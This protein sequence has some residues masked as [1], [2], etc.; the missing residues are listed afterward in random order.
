MSPEWSYEAIAAYAALSEN[1]QQLVTGDGGY[2]DPWRATCAL[3]V[4]CLNA[5]LGWDEFAELAILAPI[6]S[7]SDGRRR[8]ENRK[9]SRL[10]RA[11]TWATANYREPVRGR[12]GVLN[13]LAKLS[14]RIDRAG[15]PGRSGTSDHAVAMALVGLAHENCRVEVAA[16]QRE[17]SLRAGVGKGTVN[18][19]I[20][21]LLK[22]GLLEPVVDQDQG[23][24]D[25]RRYRLNLGWRVGWYGDEREETGHSDTSPREKDP[26]D[27]LVPS[28]SHPAFYLGAIGPT[29]GRLY[30][31]VLPER[32][33]TARQAGARLGMSAKAA[34]GNLERLV[35]HGLASKGRQGRSAVY[36]Y[37][38]VPA[39]RLDE[40]AAEYGTADW[41]ER[42]SERYDRER[43]GY[44]VRK[45]QERTSFR[46]D[47]TRSYGVRRVLFGDA[48][49]AT[50]VGYTYVVD[51]EDPRQIIA[52]PVVHE[53]D[54]RRIRERL[55]A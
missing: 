46:F 50:P 9:E 55:Y 34:R 36:E 28:A 22:I 35:R 54:Q 13:A 31:E 49:P 1:G 18:R 51:P 3:A 43:Q 8:R 44:A 39:D 30:F 24:L 32:S 12:E 19:S 37:T 53:R 23:E 20:P 15:W 7:G 11:W 6:D 40:L 26:S 29:A 16:G 47:P 10:E 38:E 2:A 4:H 41:R 45:H 5:G 52:A 33:V 25:A 42:T 17:L 27:P 48:R 21:R 14:H